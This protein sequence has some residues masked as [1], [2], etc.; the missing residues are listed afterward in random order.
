MASHNWESNQTTVSRFLIAG[1]RQSSKIQDSSSS[2]LSI[3]FLTLMF[4]NS[5]FEWEE[6]C[7]N[8]SGARR[9]VHTAYIVFVVGSLECCFLIRSFFQFTGMRGNT[10]Y[11][12]IHSACHL[13]WHVVRKYRLSK[14]KASIWRYFV[15]SDDSRWFYPS[16]LSTHCL[17][18][19]YRDVHRVCNH[20]AHRR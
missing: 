7:M 3:L 13:A 12:H 5:N 18:A 10:S 17:P 2:V 14:R 4:S 9:S 6:Q 15:L 19:Y 16:Q 20:H 8:Y 11:G 1:R